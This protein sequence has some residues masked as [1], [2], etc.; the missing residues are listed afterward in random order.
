[1]KTRIMLAVLLA[2]LMGVMIG[3]A[4]YNVRGAVPLMNRIE[5]NKLVKME[6][7]GIEVTIF[8]IAN[9]EDAK[10]Y[11]DENIISDRMFAVFL[12]VFNKTSNEVK[13]VSSEL[14]IGQTVLQPS[15]AEEMYRVIKREYGVKA[16]LWMFPTLYIGAPISA[17]HTYSVNNKIEADIKE[18]QMEFHKE[19]KPSEVLQG[20]IWFKVPKKA[21][22]EYTDKGLPKGTVLNLIL[23]QEKRVIEFGLPVS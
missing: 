13:V 15:T 8:P 11:F 12:N 21:A 19:I 2:S 23:E 6:K 3:C 20:F 17:I 18:K 22:P 1:M 9:V 7:E 16:F 14:R 4:G 5:K 10:K